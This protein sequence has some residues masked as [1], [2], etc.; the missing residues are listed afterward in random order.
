MGIPVKYILRQQDVQT[1]TNIDATT[2][3]PNAKKEK[4]ARSEGDSIDEAAVVIGI[5]AQSITSLL[6]I[7]ILVR[8]ATTQDKFR[9]PCRLHEYHFWTL[10]I[11]STCVTNT[12]SLT[13]CSLPACRA[14][15]NRR[16]LII[17]CRDHRARLG[18]EET[19]DDRADE[20]TVALSIKA[21]ISHAP[22]RD[23]PQVQE[24]EDDDKISVMSVSTVS[25]ASLFLKLPLLADLSPNNEPFECPICFTL[26]YFKREKTW[27]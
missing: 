15:A 1:S 9:K 3:E 4:V 11:Q 13:K 26:Q 24:E 19:E 10:T 22:T 18:Y 5:I 12:P 16:Q 27:Q 25:D 6:Q 14:I 20:I 7:G 2:G 23:P 8:K 21:S 17:Y